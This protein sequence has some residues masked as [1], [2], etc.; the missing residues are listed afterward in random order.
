MG[1][2]LARPATRAALVVMACKLAYD[3][4]VV[5]CG[6]SVLLVAVVEREGQ[7]VASE[8]ACHRLVESWG[9][10]TIYTHSCSFPLHLAFVSPSTCCL[11]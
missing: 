11:A 8:E 10:S 5:R 3:V 2:H 6:G 1:D 7:F 4:G 9:T